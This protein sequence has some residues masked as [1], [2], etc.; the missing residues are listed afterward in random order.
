MDG[1]PEVRGERCMRYGWCERYRGPEARAVRRR[2]GERYDRCVTDCTRMLV[3]TV[4]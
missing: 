3:G 4:A 1:A 2:G